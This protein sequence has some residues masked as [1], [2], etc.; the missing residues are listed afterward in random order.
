MATLLPISPKVLADLEWP[1][2]LAALAE[3]ARTDLGRKRC[4]DRP[5]LDSADE[6]RTAL[7]H[8]EELEV[9]T[10]QSLAL[11]SWG[12]RDIRVLVDR[13]AKGGTLEAQ[14]LLGCASVLAAMLRVK[15]F[16]DARRDRLPR[17]RHAGQ[18]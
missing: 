17:A 13:A 12:V 4:L 9:L 10:S 1:K 14:E 6:V 8:V 7:A 2:L 16:V 5:F 15:D 11:P 3:R 18:G